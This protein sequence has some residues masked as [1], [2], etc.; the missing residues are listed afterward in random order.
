MTRKAQ[1]LGS[2]RDVA[3]EDPLDGLVDDPGAGDEE[4][5]GLDE[6]GEV[7]DLAVAVG[8][9]LVGGPVRDADGDEGDERRR[10][11]RGPNGPPRPG[12]PSEPL[13]RPT[14]SFMPVR[15]RAATTELA[16]RPLLLVPG[17]VD[18]RRFFG[19]HG[20][21][22]PGETV[23]YHGRGDLRQRRPRPLTAPRAWSIFPA[24]RAGPSRRR[25]AIERREVMD[26]VFLARLQFGLTAGFHFLFPPTT[27][28]L[29]LLVVIIEALYVRT[30]DEV[31]K[32]AVRLS[33]QDPRDRLR[34]G[35]GHGHRPRI[36]LRQQLG[37]LF[38]DG[39]RY[40]RRA[41]R[42]RGRLLLFPRVRLPGHPRL[43]PEPRLRE[44]LPALG[45]PRLLRR[46]PVGAVDHHRQFL[47]A[48]AG[49][50][51]HGGRPG[52]PR[53][54]SAQAAF[55]PST[56]VRFVHTILGGWITG[57]P[58]GHGH[59]RLAHAQGTVRGEGRRAHE[60]LARGIRRGRDPPARVRATPI[61]SR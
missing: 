13:R 1:R 59:R 14:T 52:R 31:Y 40:L 51:P 43:R 16:G 45:L 61:R 46:P 53:Q 58:R 15:P 41:P 19:G 30:K 6:G 36:R 12:C 9:G 38:P 26:A 3:E 37:G 22:R 32:T 55:N 25:R 5:H 44:G 21:G 2:T 20:F 4:E 50:L 17:H 11:G 7:L 27:L 23:F 28:G 48:D 42:R 8:V 57:R 35:R 54:T 49:R 47:D 29:S 34:H 39:R 24:P 18:G 60:D 10:R 33:R 56:V